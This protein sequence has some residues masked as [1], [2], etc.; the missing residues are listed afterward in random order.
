MIS[1]CIILTTLVTM[2][3]AGWFLGPSAKE[4]IET[5]IV[6]AKN[7]NVKVI[8]SCLS[9]GW[10]VETKD[11]NGNT[12]L[13][14]AAIN[15]KLNVI[16]ALA[17]AGADMDAKLNNGKTRCSQLLERH[18]RCVHPRRP[19]SLLY[20]LSLPPLHLLSAAVGTCASEA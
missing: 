12:A 11:N 17:K 14:H 3:R 20:H 16:A 2:C 13:H 15:G 6:A 1:K 18:Q 7:G 4:C 9:A 5:T 8:E 19:C 10:H